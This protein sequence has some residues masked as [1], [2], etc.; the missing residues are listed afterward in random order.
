[1]T[2]PGQKVSTDVA[3]RIVA[4]HRRDPELTLK[5]LAL[6]FGL[7]ALTVTRILREAGFVV[8]REAGAVAS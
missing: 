1:M 4:A 7:S 3:A 6:R 8:G 2:K 5:D